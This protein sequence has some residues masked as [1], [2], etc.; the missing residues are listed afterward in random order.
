MA[1]FLAIVVMTTCTIIFVYYNFF[2]KSDLLESREHYE[3]FLLDNGFDLKKV[4]VLVA[5]I[6]LNMA[7]LHHSPFDMLLY[8][9]GRSMLTRT[10]GA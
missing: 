4:K 2:I 7:P 5:L 9:L 6:F 8:S 3:Q 1:C 10:L